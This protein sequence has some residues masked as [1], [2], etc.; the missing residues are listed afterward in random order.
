MQYLNLTYFG[1]LGE[2]APSGVFEADIFL[3]DDARS[4]FEVD[5]FLVHEIRRRS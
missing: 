2:G 3:G 5:I 4:V 1:F